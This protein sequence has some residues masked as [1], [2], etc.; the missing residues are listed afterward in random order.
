MVS[1]SE[2]SYGPYKPADHLIRSHKDAGVLNELGS[3]P[4]A[5][6]HLTSKIVLDDWLGAL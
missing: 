4:R 2:N 1:M 6:K 3:W 5:Y